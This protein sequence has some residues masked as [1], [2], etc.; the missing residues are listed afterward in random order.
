MQVF[1][2]LVNLFF[3]LLLPFNQRFGWCF[4]KSSILTGPYPDLRLLPIMIKILV[5]TVHISKSEVKNIAGQFTLSFL[6][7]TLEG[8]DP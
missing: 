2:Y 7:G 8:A 3:E 5:N 4:L 6:A 1:F